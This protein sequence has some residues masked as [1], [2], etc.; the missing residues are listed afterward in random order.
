MHCRNERFVGPAR[1]VYLS[2]IQRKSV[3]YSEPSGSTIARLGIRLLVSVSDRF[4]SY[5]ECTNDNVS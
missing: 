3:I 2:R 5:F 4:P 1:K